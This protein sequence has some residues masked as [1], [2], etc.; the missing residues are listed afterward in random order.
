M[1][2]AKIHSLLKMLK[3]MERNRK[4]EKAFEF[5]NAADDL[6]KNNNIRCA[7]SLYWTSLRDVI[8]SKLEDD[9][10]NYRS[11]NEAVLRFI[12][13]SD[14][15]TA[16]KT[17]LSYILGIR[18]DWD[19]SLNFR[20][21]NECLQESVIEIKEFVSFLSGEIKKETDFFAIKNILYQDST[22]NFNTARIFEYCIIVVGIIVAFSHKIILDISYSSMIN[23]LYVTL[24]LLFLS[25][26]AWFKNKSKDQY[27]S[28]ERLR[29][30][31]FL[32]EI[33]PANFDEN[34]KAGI[35]DNIEEEYFAKAGKISAEIKNSDKYLENFNDS[36][37]KFIFRL[38]ENTFFTYMLYGRYSDF[39]KRK[40][41]YSFITVLFII[42]ITIILYSLDFIKSSTLIPEILPLFI[43]MIAVSDLLGIYSSMRKKS[44][45]IKN[46]DLK[47]EKLM[48]VNDERKAWSLFDYYNNILWDVYPVIPKK[49]FESNVGTLNNLVKIR[50]EKYYYGN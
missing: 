42:C 44:E 21:E 16:K 5:K 22:K 46:I 17:M 41:F 19:E 20:S 28:A 3:T 30:F 6:L 4:I 25:M 31:L 9:G 34:I 10:E 39:I 47:I 14:V 48:A 18:A 11:T 24:T 43:S 29:Q 13:N 23:W 49:F 8:F 37:K 12:K 33:F 35:V 32:N 1:S 15:E 7:V 50:M 26:N 40:I 36:E 45:I 38:Q 27:Q 2:E